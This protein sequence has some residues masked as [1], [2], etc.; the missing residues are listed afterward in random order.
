MEANKKTLR[1][2]LESALKAF[3][4]N[5]P[6][7]H[8]KNLEEVIITNN[9]ASKVKS[10]TSK[11]TTFSCDVDMNDSTME[12]KYALNESNL[13]KFYKQHHSNEN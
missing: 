5:D 9:D 4:K 6:L 3:V 10:K 11:Y 2:E 12:S 13:D 8:V 7:D 1:E